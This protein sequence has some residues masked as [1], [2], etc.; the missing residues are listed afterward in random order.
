MEQRGSWRG[1]TDGVA[2]A[3]AQ[4]FLFCLLQCTSLVMISQVMYVIGAVMVQL[5]KGIAFLL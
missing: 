3:A 4:S 2:A 5:G 1:V